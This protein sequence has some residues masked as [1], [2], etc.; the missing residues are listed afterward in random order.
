MFLP[1]RWLTPDD[2]RPKFA[3]FPF[4]GG[5]RVCIGERFAQAEGI[6][7]LAALAQ[8]W[9]FAAVPGHPVQHHAQL[10]LRPRHG[11]RMHLNAR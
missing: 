5:T 2:H 6:L 4:G 8:K 7:L 11:I 1:E 3:Y 10:T 9:R